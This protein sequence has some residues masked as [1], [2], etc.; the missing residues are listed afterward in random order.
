MRNRIL[1]VSALA[2]AVLGGTA[3]ALAGGS[4]H[5]S[6]SPAATESTPIPKQLAKVHQRLS[7][8]LNARVNC[9]SIRCIN[10]ALN[11][12]T[13]AVRTLNRD[14]N[15]CERYINVTRYNGYLYTP[16]GGTTIF[17]TTALDYTD[18]GDP[19]TDKVLVF[20]C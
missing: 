2:T 14:V 13:T 10:R 12:L 11:R 3:F 15:T 8:T 19:V 6:P 16:D 20:V 1:V 4:E 18:Q 7:Q 17:E 5:R 9:G